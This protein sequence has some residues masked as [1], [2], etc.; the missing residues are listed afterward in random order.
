MKPDWS[1]LHLMIIREL[2]LMF[3]ESEITYAYLAAAH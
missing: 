2:C 1:V 3:N